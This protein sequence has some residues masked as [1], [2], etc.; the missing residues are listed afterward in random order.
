MRAHCSGLKLHQRAGRHNRFRRCIKAQVN[1][2]SASACTACTQEV[3]SSRWRRGKKNPS[4]LHA[5]HTLA[6]LPLHTNYKC[7][8][9]QNNPAGTAK[10]AHEEMHAHINVRSVAP[11]NKGHRC[12]WRRRDREDRMFPPG[13]ATSHSQIL[14]LAHAW[15]EAKRPGRKGLVDECCE[16]MVFT[17]GFGQRQRRAR[18][19]LQRMLM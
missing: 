1:N 15:L 18:D 4:A 10:R 3:Q 16:R 8:V 7:A 5:H 19:H 14:N 13:S 6:P 17:V 12:M 9:K 11:A 2:S